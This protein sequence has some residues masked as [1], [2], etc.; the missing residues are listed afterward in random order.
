VFPRREKYVVSISTNMVKRATS[1]F[2]WMTF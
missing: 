2:N 1:L